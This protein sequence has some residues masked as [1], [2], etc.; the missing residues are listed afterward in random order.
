MR[1]LPPFDA[2]VA[3]DTT[4]R[5]R[6][7]TLAAAE[8]GITQSA[9]SHRL[10]RLES[11]IGAPLLSRTS[12]GLYA[13]PT[14]AALAAGLADLLD[15]LADLRARCRVASAPAGL[16]V[17]VGAAL[18]DNWLV[19][20]LPG[21]AQTYPAIA[22]ELSIVETAAQAGAPDVD[23]QVLWLPAATARAASTQRLLFQEQVFPV[24]HPGLLPDGPLVDPA[25]LARLPLLHKGPAGRP[26]GA[27]W[28]W[29]AW[30]ERLGI[31]GPPPAGLRFGT[32]GTAIAAALQGAGVVLARSLLVH[33]ALAEGR[34]VR[35]LPESWDMASS[36]AHLVRWP[37]ALTGDPRVRQ[38]VTWLTA[39]ADRT[40]A[41]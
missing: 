28:S 4:L 34:L 39:E 30:F 13:T 11:F 31:A 36:K 27:E 6:S 40:V 3:F 5:H 29:S 21:F 9:I 25:G 20:R 1:S 41:S 37:G 23:V 18:A 26:G 7:M 33:D 14:G 12:A 15:G 16:R 35:V 2:L 8:L 24:C 32:V 10:R 19:R 22:V 17:G 38:F